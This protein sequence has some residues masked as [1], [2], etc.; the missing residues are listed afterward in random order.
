MT[1]EP[2]GTQSVKNARKVPVIFS[3]IPAARGGRSGTACTVPVSIK[4][5]RFRPMIRYWRT[6]A[7]IMIKTR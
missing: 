2:M 3:K 1:V 7:A 6:M 5:N 4:S